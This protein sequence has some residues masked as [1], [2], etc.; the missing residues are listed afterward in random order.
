MAQQKNGG[1][2]AARSAAICRRELVGP[3]RVGVVDGDR[4]AGAGCRRRADPSRPRSASGSSSTRP[5]RP[6]VGA[7][8]LAARAT[9][10]HSTASDAECWMTPPPVPLGAEVG[11]EGEQL[12]QPV[13][14]V[15][16]E[17]GA[18]RARSTTASP[19]CRGRPRPAR[20]GCS[21][22]CRWP[23]STRTSPGAAS[24]WWPGTTMRSRSATIASQPSPCSG[25]A[26]GSIAR[27]SPG[28]H[29]AARPAAPRRAPC[30]RRPT[31]SARARP[32][33][34]SSGD[35]CGDVI[36]DERSRMRQT[37]AASTRSRNCEASSR[38]QCSTNSA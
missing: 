25:A 17:L 14:D 1:R 20:R 8:L 26:A 36:A 11:G 5:A 29:G 4:R 27:T 34:N 32:A 31:R 13:H 7:R 10:A 19:A 22:R 16:L 35:M 33:R 18:D 37:S 6:P 24:A 23:G 2:P 12:D 3:H 28:A 21:G 30:R 15:R 9:I 38:S